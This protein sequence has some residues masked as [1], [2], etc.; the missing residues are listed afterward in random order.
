MIPPWGWDETASYRAR[1]EWARRF[2][3]AGHPTLRI[4]LPGAG[5][6]SG[7]PGDPGLFD[8]W[9]EAVADAA[10]WLRDQS[11]ASRVV[12]LGL[13][14]GGLLAATAVER[15]AE[16]D[17]LVLWAAPSQGKRFLREV[18]SFARMQA[19]GAG[20]GE[21]SP[22]PDGWLEAAGFV[23]SAETADALRTISSP[24]SS[25]PQRLRRVLLLDR[26]GLM[27][28][29]R[30]AERLRADGVDTTTAPGPGWGAMVAYREESAV[31]EE[32][33]ERV[34]AWLAGGG[35][36]DGDKSVPTAGSGDSAAALELDDLT[37]RAIAI[38]Q[39]AGDLFGVVAEPR[40]E[41]PED[42]CVVF[43]NA[44]EVRHIGPN[45]NWVEHARRW[46]ARGVP[47]VRVDLEGIG[48]ADGERRRTRRSRNSTTSSTPPSSS[49]SSTRSN[50]RASVRASSASASAPAPTGP[51]SSPIATHG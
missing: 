39:Q 42:L 6:S 18:D 47:S 5:N 30:L 17:E 31:P 21:E 13:G 48:E 24:L 7:D 29:K 16:V 49:P 9:I 43:L 15:G 36:G 32:T 34:E 25:A 38:P 2:V 8:A 4:D 41:R 22:L 35:D 10:R 28:D 19:W 20:R 45:R 23:I 14:L 50:D 1:R 27:S 3:A 37:E 11:G 51:Y 44:G 12:V 46:A 33:I 40:G 26:D